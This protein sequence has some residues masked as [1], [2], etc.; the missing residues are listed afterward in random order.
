MFDGLGDPMVKQRHVK[1]GDGHITLLSDES[2][3]LRF[4]CCDC[5]GDS[6]VLIMGRSQPTTINCDEERRCPECEKKASG[7]HS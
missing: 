7:Q 5:D 3:L 6:S 1:Q 4:K 2:A